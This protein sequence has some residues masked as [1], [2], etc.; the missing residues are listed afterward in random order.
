MPRPQ[1]PPHYQ[2]QGYMQQPNPQAPQHTQIYYTPGIPSGLPPMVHPQFQHHPMAFQQQHP[3]LPGATLLQFTT[4]PHMGQMQ[5]Q[6]MQQHQQQ[7]Q[8]QQLQ[9]PPMSQAQMGQPRPLPTPTPPNQVQVQPP[10]S[11]PHQMVQPSTM[12]NANI[13]PFQPYGHQ[14]TQRT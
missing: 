5:P 10:M 14:V 9:Q 2:N 12:L 1:G 7:Q 6:L 11:M 4:Q 13:Q 3:G 8:M